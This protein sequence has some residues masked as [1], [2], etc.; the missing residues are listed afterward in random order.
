MSTLKKFRIIDVSR[1]GKISP[2]LN[3]IWLKNQLKQVTEQSITID[4]NLAFYPLSITLQIAFLYDFVVLSNFAID[5]WWGVLLN[6]LF[7]ALFIIQ[8]IILFVNIFIDLRHDKIY[9]LLEEV[10]NKLSQSKLT[11]EE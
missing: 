3:F 6:I 2:G 4:T 5:W 9:Q 10:E 1:D 8:L 7:F 11:E